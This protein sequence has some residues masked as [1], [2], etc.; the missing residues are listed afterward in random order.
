M[1]SAT[2]RWSLENRL[3][4]LILSGLL[5]LGGLW[6]LRNLPMDAFP[7]TTPVQVQINTVAPN[8][9]PEEIEQQITLPVELSISGLP[10]LEVMRSLS[11]FGFSQVIAIF[12]DGTDIYLARQLV[13]ER[14]QGID[15]PEGVEVPEMGPISTGLGEVFH[16][17]VK[18]SSR[19]LTELRTLHD[20]VVKPILSS[21]PGVAE[22]NTWGGLVKQYQVSYDPGLLLKHGLTL[23]DLSRALEENNRNVGGGNIVQSGEQFLVHGLGLLHTIKEIEDVSI[24][25]RDGVPIRVGDVATV[26]FGHEI[27]RGAVTAMGEGEVVLGLAFMLTGENSRVV[28]GRLEN[29]LEEVRKTLPGDVEIEVAYSRIALVDAVLETVRRNLFEGAILVIA[30]LFALMGSFRAGVITALAIPL[31][32]LFAFSAMLKCGIAGS[33]MSLGAI[34]FGIVVDSSVIMV[35]NASRRVGE[36]AGSSKKRID[37]VRDACLEVRRPTLFGEAIVMIVYLPILTLQGIEGKLFRP[38]ALTFLFCMLGS[39]I[40]SMTLMPVLASLFVPRKARPKEVWIMRLALA[41]YA[42]LLRIALRF[43]GLVLVLTILVMLATGYT[44]S[45]LGTEFVPELSEGTIVLNTVRLAGVSLE[46]SVRY[47]DRIEDLLLAEFPDEIQKVWTRTG[48]PEVATD[49]MGVELS[50]FFIT[51]H[52]RHEWKRASEQEELVEIMSQTLEGL[53]GMRVI[54]TQPI[55]MRLAEMV[56]GSRAD[57]AVKVFGDDLDNLQEIAGE[58]DSLLQQVPGSADVQTDQLIGQPILQTRLNRVALARH[59]ISGDDVSEVVESVG[60]IKVGEIREGQRRFDLVVRLDEMYRE[61]PSA[62]EKVFVPSEDGPSLPLGM[63]VDVAYTEGPASINREWGKRRVTIQCNVRGRDVGSFVKEVRERIA[64]EIPLPV[65]YYIDFG[66]QFE[67]MTAAKQ[68]LMLVVP[69]ALSLIFALLYLA[70]GSM[71]DAILVFTLVPCAVVG[72]VFSLH[73]RGMPFTVSAAVGFIALSGIVILNGLL[74]I[75]YAK[76]LV[77]EGKDLRTAVYE[78]ALRRL[79]PVLATAIT[80]A[81]GFIPMALSIG[82]GAEVQRPLATVVIGGVISST[83]LTL[84]VLPV[85]YSIFGREESAERE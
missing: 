49:P 16:Y 42:P 54:F 76:R 66:G 65:G 62:L 77:R 46:E 47:G 80:D 22:V 39:L 41:L 44:A 51:L 67:H 38:M 27:R 10:G 71:R 6:S 7:D 36:A 81:A 50:D 18:S 69:L 9:S 26:R 45:R 20:W 1:L 35:E 25:T 57:V 63:L 14:L 72:G 75:T 33:L 82:V 52:P 48:A 56:A 8:L 31:S 84:F 68:R 19:D 3:V 4:V 17:L 2:I 61:H 37:V 29:K 53:P 13:G 55:E 74:V 5:V 40:L 15:L 79:R 11:R 32:M 30:V 58:V 73:W 59:G 28:T 23:G 24:A 85:L 83:I 34:D 12:E 43:R 78:S 21:V 70:Y 64:Q 60:G